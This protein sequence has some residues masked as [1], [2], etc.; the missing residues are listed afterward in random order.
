MVQLLWQ[1]VSGP[2]GTEG[3][4]K[5]KEL[6]KSQVLG[7]LWKQQGPSGSAGLEIPLAVVRAVFWKR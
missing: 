5:S 6:Y 3:L 7:H 1:M 4:G 2:A